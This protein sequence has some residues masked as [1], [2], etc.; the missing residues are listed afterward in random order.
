MTMIKVLT[1]F[2][3]LAVVFVVYIFLAQVILMQCSVFFFFFLLCLLSPLLKRRMRLPLLPPQHRP[4]CP[5]R[6]LL[7][8]HGLSAWPTTLTRIP[9][10]TSA[11]PTSSWTCRRSP[12]VHAQVPC[13][14]LWLPPAQQP[15]R[16]RP[17]PPRLLPPLPPPSPRSS[18]PSRCCRVCRPKVPRSTRFPPPW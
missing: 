11:P 2:K 17:P 3:F 4:L 10:P 7:P 15:S 5:W 1:R 14:L 13:P 6:P 16:P 18:S 12:P 8:L 9:S